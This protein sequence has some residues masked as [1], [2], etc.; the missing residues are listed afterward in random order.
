MTALLDMC[1]VPG[2]VLGAGDREE[3][4]INRV[5]AFTGLMSCLCWGKG[6]HS[7]NNF[8]NSLMETYILFNSS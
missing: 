1:Y 3:N 6:V 4:I 2:P 5:F 7:T 8:R